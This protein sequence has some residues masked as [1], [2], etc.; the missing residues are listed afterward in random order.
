MHHK[1][2]ERDRQ[3]QKKNDRRNPAEQGH[4]RILFE[5]A[6]RDTIFFQLPKAAEKHE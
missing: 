3:L 6:A 1:P 5:P 4:A 2:I